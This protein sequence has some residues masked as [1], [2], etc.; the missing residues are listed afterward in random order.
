VIGD[1][2]NAGSIGVHTKCGFEMIGTHPNVGFKFGRWLDTVMMQRA[3]G[4]GA[5]TLPADDLPQA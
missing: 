3:L 4:D 5:K 1:S 2:A